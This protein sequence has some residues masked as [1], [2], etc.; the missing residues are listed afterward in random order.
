[1]SQGPLE[2]KAASFATGTFNTTNTGGVSSVPGDNEPLQILKPVTLAEIPT[3]DISIEIDSFRTTGYAAHGDGGEGFYVR[4]ASEPAHAGK[5]QSNDGAWWRLV[6]EKG[7]VSVLQFGA[8]RDAS[9]TPATSSHQAFQDAI[10]FVTEI[11]G[12][13]RDEGLIVLVPAGIYYWSDPVYILNPVEI[14]GT[15]RTEIQTAPDITALTVQ[16][17][18]GTPD[19]SQPFDAE[20]D[21][22][23]TVI[24]ELRIRCD[25][26]A[27]DVQTP[28]LRV[29]SRCHL[30]RVRVTDAAGAGIHIQATFAD[31][32]IASGNANVF[33]ITDCAA[34]RNRGDGLLIEGNDAN[35]GH[36]VGFSAVGNER[37][38]IR[39]SSFLG[40]TISGL[41]LDGN[42]PAF[43][44]TI[45]DPDARAGC[46]YQGQRYIC[47]FG[48][49][50]A[51]YIATTPGTDDNVWIPIGAGGDDGN[52][53][54]EW[55]GTEPEGRFVSGG[56]IVADQSLTGIFGAYFEPNQ[57]PAQIK[58]MLFTGHLAEKNVGGTVFAGNSVRGEI[59]FKPENYAQNVTNGGLVLGRPDRYFRAEPT[60]LP[61]DTHFS[62]IAEADQ[63][64]YYFSLHGVAGATGAYT[65]SFFDSKHDD[66]LF[67]L[68]V[69]AG[70]IG[71]DVVAVDGPLAFGVSAEY[72]QWDFTANTPNFYSNHPHADGD[73]IW[74]FSVSSAQPEAGIRFTAQFDPATDALADKAVELWEWPTLDRALHPPRYTKAEIDALDATAHDRALLFSPD[75]AG[76]AP[77]LVVSDEAAWRALPLGGIATGEITDGGQVSGVVTWNLATTRFL[78]LEPTGDTQVF[79]EGVAA[80]ADYE[81]I[82]ELVGA[83][84]HTVAFYAA[85]STDNAI[86][87]GGSA[88]TFA[89]GTGRDLVRA[90]SDGG[91]VALDRLATGYAPVAPAPAAKLA[92]VRHVR[93][94]NVGAGTESI[95]VDT[96]TGGAGIG[97]I[98]AV[99]S[100]TE[101]APTSVERDGTPLTLVG[102]VYD[103]DG[104]NDNMVHVYTDTS[105][106]GG[107]ATYDIAWPATSKA[108]VLAVWTVD[109]MDLSAAAATSS[110]DD[111][112]DPATGVAVPAGGCAVSAVITR[113]ADKAI[114]YGDGGQTDI[115]DLQSAGLGSDAR[116]GAMSL[117]SAAGQ[118][119]TVDNASGVS[120]Q[121]HLTVAFAPLP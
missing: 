83:G 108:L 114:M 34:N 85:G 10:D 27:Y 84:D 30:H 115:L 53:Y 29:R 100:R 76:G 70:E 78:R 94:S 20:N 82:L 28:G 111:S 89:T 65:L 117:F 103:N 95:A 4:A 8:I 59:S 92:F 52:Y 80:G 50:E 1:M 110:K 104:S 31:T 36:I 56:P 96:G 55:T 33:S 72:R 105:A 113:F 17:G 22:G 12:A 48:A 68:D 121:A 73:I 57:Y 88:P 97:R 71:Q 58:G 39:A 60:G 13:S 93:D 81:S 21:A 79:I 11:A 74:N 18:Y 118:S 49:S 47:R 44:G 41:H 98:V 62:L 54:P 7:A 61:Y 90:W 112:A 120:R 5:V 35:A 3:I 99:I 46:S 101:Q 107:T 86:W 9:A 45:S 69:A 64:R 51:D 75:Y 66:A 6:P 119:W 116:V 25:A 23:G 14:V 37:W 24:E 16:H 26:T 109:G 19:G 42:G 67:G 32:G 102:S 106:T 87:V 40:N 91:V 77:A 15:V 63:P 38:G 2:T 43:T